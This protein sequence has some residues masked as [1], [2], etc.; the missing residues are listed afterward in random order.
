MK[1]WPHI[2]LTT[3]AAI[4][5][6]LAQAQIIV[7]PPSPEQVP[8]GGP[9]M[10]IGVAVT[11]LGLAFKFRKQL[12]TKATPLVL[13]IAATAVVT[14]TEW[15]PSSYAASGSSETITSAQGKTVNIV[16]VITEIT[17]DSGVT[18][19][20][21]SINYRIDNGGGSFEV[22]TPDAASSYT[23]AAGQHICKPG[24]IIIDGDS[25]RLQCPPVI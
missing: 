18:L 5:P 21:K 3:L 8:V 2:L 7:V 1:S 13:V 9:L 20:V 14:Q 11:L 4:I 24:Q 22:C 12:S 16:G 15:L 10:L 25:C 23:L 19:E 17:N 6:T